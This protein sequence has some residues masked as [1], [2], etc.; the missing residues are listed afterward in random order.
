MY[1]LSRPEEF[2]INNTACQIYINLE[3]VYKIQ[4]EFNTSIFNMP[5]ILKDMDGDKTAM[6][7]Y[8]MTGEKIELSIID[9]YNFTIAFVKALK[10]SIKTLDKP[11]E[12]TFI[13]NDDIELE[14]VNVM[15]LVYLGTTVLHIDIKTVW[16]MTIGEIISLYYQ[17]Q[18]YTGI[19]ETPKS[20]DDVIPY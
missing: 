5:N 3:K 20:I 4:Q 16:H 6:L 9:K 15:R 11:T 2:K 12:E 14:N 1:L 13:S 10:K 19:I 17:H 8:I 7:F 18:L